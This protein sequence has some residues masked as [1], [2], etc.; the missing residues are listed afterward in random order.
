MN[1]QP[2]LPKAHHRALIAAFGLLLFLVGTI[3]LFE[4]VARLER[5]A[6]AVPNGLRSGSPYSIAGLHFFPFFIFL[7]L[8]WLRAGVIPAI[9]SAVYLTLIC[10]GVIFRVETR[11]DEVLPPGLTLLAALWSAISYWDLLGFSISLALLG[12]L[13]LAHCRARRIVLTQ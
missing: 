2:I 4:S 10:L 1:E 3:F 12:S 13:L 7:P 6:E 11:Y 5:M 9:L 8:I